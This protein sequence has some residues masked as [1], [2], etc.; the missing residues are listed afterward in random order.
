MTL[1][2]DKHWL[3]LGMSKSKTS[4]KMRDAVEI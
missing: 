4:W 3:G 2:R 1:R